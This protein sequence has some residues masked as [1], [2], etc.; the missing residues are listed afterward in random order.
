[1]LKLVPCLKS[2][3]YLDHMLIKVLEGFI[4]V[5]GDWHITEEESESIWSNSDIKNQ[6]NLIFILKSIYGVD[7]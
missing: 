1:M 3:V 7:R 5:I 4:K 6:N 2:S